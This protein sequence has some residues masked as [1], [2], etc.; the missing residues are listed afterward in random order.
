[1]KIETEKEKN[2]KQANNNFVQTLSSLF[3]SFIINFGSRF[4]SFSNDLLL[5]MYF[6]FLNLL[7]TVLVVVGVIVNSLC[8]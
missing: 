8:K 7:V 2:F 6:N 3:L 4:A 5:Y 1:M